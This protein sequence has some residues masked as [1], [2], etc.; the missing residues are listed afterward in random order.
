L[1]QLLSLTGIVALP[2][3]GPYRGGMHSHL[4]TI[5]CEFEGGSY[6]SQVR[7]P[8][9]QQALLAWA[10]GIRVDQTMGGD[11]NRIAT[12]AVE[13]ADP[14]TPLAGLEGVWCWTTNIAGKLVLANIVQ[15]G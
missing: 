7:A 5:V 14:P 10:D 9:E 12:N 6:V 15:S 11:T 1:P 8:N 3:S 4:F 13:D 2:K